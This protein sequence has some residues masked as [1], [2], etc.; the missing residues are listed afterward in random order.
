MSIG[1]RYQWELIFAQASK[2]K[3]KLLGIV[4]AILRALSHGREDDGIQRERLA[5]GK[6]HPLDRARRARI[7]LDVLECHGERG[8]ALKGWTAG[9]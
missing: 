6:M 9:G 1:L 4:V 3:G 8:L 5:V 7:I 2:I